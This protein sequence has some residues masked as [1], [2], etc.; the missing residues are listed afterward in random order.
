MEIIHPF[1]LPVFIF[2]LFDFMREACAE[3]RMVFQNRHHVVHIG[4][5]VEQTNHIGVAPQA[6]FARQRLKYWRIV[7]ILK[8]DRNG[9]RFHQRIAKIFSVRAGGVQFQLDPRHGKTLYLSVVKTVACGTDVP[10]RF[11]TRKASKLSSNEGTIG[12]KPRY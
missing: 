6:R 1:A 11:P 10:K 12:W 8:S 2:Q 3:Q 7:G 4:F 9:T 5:S